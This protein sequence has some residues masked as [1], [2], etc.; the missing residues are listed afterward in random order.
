M[1]MKRNPTSLHA[2]IIIRAGKALAS[3]TPWGGAQPK[4]NGRPGAAR[5][6][7]LLRRDH[8]IPWDDCLWGLLLNDVV[9]ARRKALDLLDRSAGPQDAHARDALHAA[10]A[11]VNARV[12]VGEIT[13]CAA[14]FPAQGFRLDTCSD[15]TPIR[16]R[17]LQ[18][19]DDRTTRTRFRAIHQEPHWATIHRDRQIEQTIAVKVCGSDSAAYVLAP[20]V[21]PGTVR[22]VFEASTVPQEIE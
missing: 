10:E 11:D 12:A 7:R 9:G 22:N 13:R 4:Q 14:H 5:F 1:W 3:P 8:G 15:R 20:Q 19:E 21:R 2:V 16:L 18:P 17:T 6:R